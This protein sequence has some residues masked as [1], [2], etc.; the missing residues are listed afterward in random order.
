MLN[1]IQ[2]ESYL[3]SKGLSEKARQYIRKVRSSEPSRSVTEGCYQNTS[4]LIY[5]EKMGHTIQSESGTGETP[6]IY[7]YEYLE[8]VYE[9][10]EQLPPVKVRGFN[11]SGNL[12]SWTIRTDFLILFKHGVEIHEIKADS[13]IAKKLAEGHPAWRKDEFG[14]V[15]Y[16]PAEQYY[17][18][19]GLK[20]RVRPISSLNKTLLSNQ[21][22]LLSSRTMKEPDLALIQKTKELLA[23]SF[24]IKMDELMAELNIR[25]A[26]PLIQMVD[27][28]LIFCELD[29]EFLSDYENVFLSLTAQLSKQ[30]RYLRISE[31]KARSL[32]TY[33]DRFLPSRK[34]AEKALDRL[35]QIEEG[36]NDSTARHW[37]KKVKDGILE[38]LTEF[39]CL[40]PKHRNCGSRKP[41]TS[42][43]EQELF[44]QSVRKYYATPK[45]PSVKS[46]YIR[47]KKLVRDIDNGD[48][49]LSE[50]AYRN[51]IK[52]MDQMKLAHARGGKRMM[53]SK[54][55]T[56]SVVDRSLKSKV[57]F[58]RAHIDHHVVKCFLV[59]GNDG[60]IEY[61]G[62]PWLTL[63]I[64]EATDMVLGYHFSFAKPTR[65]ADGCVLRDCVRRYG[66]LPEEIVA[67]HGSDFK[68]VYFRS[69]LASEKMTLTFRPKSMSKAG[70]E[71][72]R[73]FNEFQT[74][75]L[76]QRQGN[77][78]DKYAA[79]SVD[80]KFASRKM[81]VSEPADLLREFGQYLEHR[82][83]KLKGAKTKTAAGAFAGSNQVYGF[84][85]RQIVYDE[86][87][88]VSSAVETE[89]YSVDRNDI[90]ID[91]IRYSHPELRNTRLT[92]S[93]IEVRIEPENP[94]I[95]YA[96]VNNKWVSC[97]AT[98]A[99]EFMEKT[100]INQR[101]ETL[102][103]RG[104]G[105]LRSLAKENA[106][107]ELADLLDDADKYLEQEKGI[108]PVDE[109]KSDV[110]AHELDIN[111]FEQ[112][113][114]ENPQQLPTSIWSAS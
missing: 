29:Q 62:R 31:S 81:A 20:Y 52:N 87:F 98:G 94:Y 11:K 46:A 22:L 88:I 58:Q 53:Y 102:K 28:Q 43:K 65:M 8:T 32:I 76:N 70:S 51:R 75:W 68:S 35:R 24:S 9:Y 49:P 55:N 42:A 17:S 86:R 103:I 106:Q 44:F 67:D 69:L 107:S 50:K 66:K 61:V 3:E 1:D 93:K 15:H 45:R 60:K 73:F 14:E 18:S 112:L 83:N 39:E 95:V 37:K 57:A 105:T 38:G 34:E 25:D 59:W 90:K 54:S 7:E 91:E 48:E 6:A 113:A 101:V 92:K 47:Y 74:Q 85:G 27:K 111:I 2:L 56:S 114:N 16:D 96:F 36:R 99:V 26:T 10:W 97:V 84:V 40:L 21:K 63:L 12:S 72:E 108:R 33:E 100:I 78:V 109:V 80:G 30:S 19:I 79:R 23:K 5:S 104:A 110:A 82:N 89:K 13:F 71:V 64:D 4:S 77:M 41:R